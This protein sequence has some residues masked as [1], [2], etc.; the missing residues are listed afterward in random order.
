MVGVCSTQWREVRILNDLFTWWV[1][2]VRVRRQKKTKHASREQSPE[3]QAAQSTEGRHVATSL[4]MYVPLVSTNNG[5]K[6][7]RAVQIHSYDAW[8]EMTTD[9]SGMTPSW[10]WPVVCSQQTAEKRANQQRNSG[11][12]AD[13]ALH[14]LGGKESTTNQCK[15][16]SMNS[17]STQNFAK[18]S[19]CPF[20]EF[21]GNAAEQLKTVSR[22]R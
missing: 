21:V 7:V 22:N 10:L 18:H 9:I 16:G 17:S 1:I 20:P 6:S 5:M 11:H 12:V 14:S 2:V 3:L 13:R 19:L 8:A 15:L 4:L